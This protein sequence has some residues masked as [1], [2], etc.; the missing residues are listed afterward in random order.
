LSIVGAG[1]GRRTL[2]ISRSNIADRWSRRGLGVKTK[3]IPDVIDKKGCTEFEQ[4]V[5]DGGV[6]S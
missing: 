3:D 4:N 6:N 1:L 2:V 5:A